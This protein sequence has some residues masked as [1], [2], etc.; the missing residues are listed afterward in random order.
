MRWGG[1]AAVALLAAGLD[2]CGLFEHKP[3]PVVGGVQTGT[4]SW[5]GPGFHGK[6]TANGEVFDQYELTAAHP[7]LPLGTRAVV[8]NLDNGRSVE[9][10]INDRGPF[11]GGRVIDLSYAA[12]RVIGMVGPG[13]GPV[14]IEVLES[15]PVPMPRRERVRVASR[16]PSVAA[17]PAPPPVAPASPVPTIVP[18][19]EPVATT[20][21]IVEIASFGDAAKA[22]HL[23]RVL[24]GRFP[25]AAVTVL[26]GAERRYYRVSIGPYPF[27][28][29]ALARAE[30]VTRLGYPAVLAEEAIP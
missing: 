27:R 9:V 14:R 23:R 25:D 3:P 1:L 20:Q 2:G 12:A 11:V 6:R 10:R 8:T 28:T 7:S 22:E 29:V 30:L 16:E 19:P 21:W 17:P 4:A 26:D 5:Y 18:A 24:A 15:G 13:T